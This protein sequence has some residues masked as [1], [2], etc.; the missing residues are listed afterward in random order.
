MSEF[1]LDCSVTMSWCFGDEATVYG[2]SVLE[3]LA[4][5]GALAPSIWPLEVGNVL[6]AAERGG[7]LTAADS[8]RFLAL[9]GSLPIRVEETPSQGAFG[10]WLGLA[11]ALGISAYGAAYL[12][13]AVRKG[14]PLATL[15]KRLRGAARESEV[16][17]LD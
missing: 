15:D 14:A 9:L 13:L 12:E 8:A 5:S 6:L 1:V 3:G 7:R 4:D 11:R 17:L 16:P 2:D 10:D